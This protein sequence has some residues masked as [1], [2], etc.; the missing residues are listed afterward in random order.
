MDNKT[1]RSVLIKRTYDFSLSVIRL[2]K[3][4]H[5]QDLATGIIAKQLVRSATECWRKYC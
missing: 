1:Y 2:I 3:N 5:S 4:I